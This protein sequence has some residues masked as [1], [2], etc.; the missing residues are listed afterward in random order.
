VIKHDGVHGV[1]LMALEKERH[2]IEN[3]VGNIDCKVVNFD[4]QDGENNVIRWSP[5]QTIST[6]S[7]NFLNLGRQDD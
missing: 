5:R 7:P 6:T 2:I 4:G 3:I 1:V